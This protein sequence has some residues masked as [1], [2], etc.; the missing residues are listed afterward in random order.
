MTQQAR[1]YPIPGSRHVATSPPGT[2]ALGR[3]AP[4]TG[5]TCNRPRSVRSSCQMRRFGDMRACDLNYRLNRRVQPPLTIYRSAQNYTSTQ[6][7]LNTQKS[8]TL[9]PRRVGTV[10]RPRSGSRAEPCRQPGRR[11]GAGTNDG[12]RAAESNLHDQ[13]AGPRNLG[14][15][16]RAPTVPSRDHKLIRSFWLNR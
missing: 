3:R 7:P 2:I 12:G 6:R 1:T 4:R 5:F 16:A 15:K 13:R 9:Q 10:A 8:E 11:P 14:R